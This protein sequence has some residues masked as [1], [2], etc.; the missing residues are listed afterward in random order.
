MA[1]EAPEGLLRRRGYDR[2]SFHNGECSGGL[3]RYTLPL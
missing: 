2:K 1:L 3:K